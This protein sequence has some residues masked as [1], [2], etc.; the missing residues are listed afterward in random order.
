MS[1]RHDPR[2]FDSGALLL[3]R[4]SDTLRVVHAVAQAVCEPNVVEGEV[5]AVLLQHTIVVWGR[6]PV[7]RRVRQWVEPAS[8][9]Q[10]LGA[11]ALRHLTGK[12]GD[13]ALLRG[14]HQDAVPAEIPELVR[15]TLAA[16]QV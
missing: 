11:Q 13:E 5:P 8:I 1:D 6:H 12:F 3:G 2:G 4:A 14:S 9:P 16:F 10:L 7:A 15:D